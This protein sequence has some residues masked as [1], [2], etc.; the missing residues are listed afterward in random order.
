MTVLLDVFRSFLFSEV[1]QKWVGICHAFLFVGLPFLLGV[2]HGSCIFRLFPPSW[3]FV[4]LF[5]KESLGTEF[6]RNGE[7]K[8][9]TRKEKKRKEEKW[10]KVWE[11]KEK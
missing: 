11:E 5:E 1:G 2:C 8:V 9:R 6:G 7:K 3:V 4:T 10:E